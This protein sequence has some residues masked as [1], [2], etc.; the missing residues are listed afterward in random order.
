MSETEKQDGVTGAGVV[1]GVAG[2]IV[3]VVG[4][5]EN[6]DDRLEKVIHAENPLLEASRVLLRAQADMD[7]MPVTSENL[8]QQLRDMLAGEVRVFDRLCTR[9]NIR[10]DHAAGARYCL[11][12]ALDEVAMQSPWSRLNNL[13]TLWAAQTLTNTFGMDGQGGDKIYLLAARLLQEPTEHHDLLEVIYRI[14]SLGF[15]GRYRLIT[16]GPRRHDAIRQQIYN[17]I[18]AGRDPVPI[19]LSP[20][21]IAPIAARRRSFREVP[22]WLTAGLCAL[23]LLCMFGYF[24]YRLVSQTTDVQRQ[25]DAIAHLTPP[26]AP[27]ALHLKELLKDEIAAGTVS[28]DED[29]QHS[30]VTFRG[31]AMFEPGSAEIRSSKIGPLVTRIA[32]ELVKVPGQ[33]SVLG[34]SDNIPIH[35]RQYASNQELSEARA[36]Q[37]KQMLQAAGVPEGRLSALG[38]G[39][40]DPVGDNATPQGRAQNRRVEIMVNY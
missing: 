37:V 2:G 19:A 22:V 39:E 15:E 29:S 30:A 21:G 32:N 5:G 20:H 36:T 33:V 1:T 25:I 23:V 28:V 4:P 9:A 35:S 3:G 27:V 14:M 34:Y 26:A 8:M 11:C 24:K 40:A 13:S 18:T 10:A 16:D 17:A 38:K 6:E 31:D 7:R 12:T